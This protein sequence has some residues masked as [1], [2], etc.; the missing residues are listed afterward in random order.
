MTAAGNGKRPATDNT[1]DWFSCPQNIAVTDEHTHITIKCLTTDV[2]VE[3]LRTPPVRQITV[4]PQSRFTLRCAPGV[5]IDENLTVGIG[6]DDSSECVCELHAPVPHVVCSTLETR[7][8]TPVHRL[9]LEA[10]AQIEISSG[11]WSIESLSE[12]TTCSIALRI[13]NRDESLRITGDV[14]VRRLVSVGTHEVNLS[15]R[16]DSTQRA[17]V[18]VKEG[19]TTFRRPLRWIELLGD[20][21][22][23]VLHNVTECYVGLLGNLEVRGEVID[24]AIQIGG[25]FDAAGSVEI[26]EFAL[27]CRNAVIAGALKTEGDV[28]CRSLEVRGTA[29]IAGTPRLGTLRCAGALKTARLE[30]NAG[31]LVDESRHF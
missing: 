22:A 13:D 8:S 17:S 9:R 4:I 5:D 3:I 31:T 25:N 14:A 28:E 23:C 19:T 20:G 18:A 26:N 7:T 12:S 27:A 29:E 1:L 15:F 6:A 11:N 10:D 24:S 21:N 16:M 2:D 30:V